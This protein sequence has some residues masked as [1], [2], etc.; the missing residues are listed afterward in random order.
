MSAGSWTRAG[1][2]RT[3]QEALHD[4]PAFSDTRLSLAAIGTFARVMSLPLGTA[5]DAE[6]LGFAA[7]SVAKVQAALDELAA[8]GYLAEVTA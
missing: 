2:P 5:F 7:D 3:W 8:V 4:H 6:T 1:D